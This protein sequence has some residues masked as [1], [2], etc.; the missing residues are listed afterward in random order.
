MVRVSEIE[1]GPFEGKNIQVK[2]AL[3][4]EHHPTYCVFVVSL[5]DCTDGRLFPIQCVDSE[6]QEEHTSAFETYYDVG[7][8]DLSFELPDWTSV[9]LISRE[10]LVGPFQHS[11]NLMAVVRLLDLE[12][13]PKIRYGKPES[14]EGVIWTG[15]K[16]FKYDLYDEDGYLELQ[17]RLQRFH[18]TSIGFAMLIAASGGTIGERAMGEIQMKMHDW[19]DKARSIDQIYDGFS[20]DEE[21][22]NSYTKQMDDALQ[23]AKDRTLRQSRL[24]TVLMQSYPSSLTAELIEFCFDVAVAS[25]V[26]TSQSLDLIDKIAKTIKID[27][28]KFKKIRDDRILK[29][30]PEVNLDLRAEQLLGINMYWKPKK[31]IEHLESEFQKWNS[32]LNVVPEGETRENIQRLLNMIGD[33]LKEYR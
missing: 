7:E 17:T 27:P 20:S 6:F 15:M 12:A 23:K 16:K 13:D 5:F 10:I 9:G 30:N 4:Y 18:Y 1:F 11:R 14:S 24:M 22:F 32:R 29:I 19:L 21:R 3:P 8:I 28:D 26:I 31:K 25:E 2:G 33:A